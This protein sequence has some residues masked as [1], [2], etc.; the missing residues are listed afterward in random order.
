[1]KR[2]GLLLR[3]WFY[4]GGA[5]VAEF[6]TL[7][8]QWLDAQKSLYQE[9]ISKRKADYLKKKWPWTEK[10]VSEFSTRLTEIEQLRSSVTTELNFGK[11]HGKNLLDLA[12]I[13]FN[14]AGAASAKGKVAIAYAWINRT[15]GTMREPKST[16]EV[17]HYVT[18]SERWDALDD[19]QRMTFLKNFAICLS[20]ARQRLDDHTPEKSDPTRGATHWVSPISLPAYKS[21]GGRYER[22]VGTAVRR[23]FPVWARSNTDPEVAKMKK[24]GQVGTTYAEITVSGV[25]PSEFL[26]YTGVK[27]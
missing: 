8:E 7:V 1:M 22:T 23:G 14:E 11:A 5:P 4:E 2:C 21:Q 9:L 27:Y 25:D 17:S 10:A 20:V 6:Q 24:Q 12:N 18:L 19:I 16:S 3:C 13:V 26:F 15:R